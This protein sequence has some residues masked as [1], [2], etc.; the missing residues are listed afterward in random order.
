MRHFLLLARGESI[1]TARV[2]AVS[3]DPSIVGRFVGELVGEAEDG[4]EIGETEQREPLRLVPGG[5]E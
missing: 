3:A 5:D 2:V 1:G 4:E